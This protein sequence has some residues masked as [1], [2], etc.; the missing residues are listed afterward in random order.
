MEEGQ[1]DILLAS[2][3]FMLIADLY[4]QL[5]QTTEN[6]HKHGILNIVF[7]EFPEIVFCIF[8]LFPIILVWEQ[9]TKPQIFELL[10]GKVE[11][12]SET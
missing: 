10:S 11:L 3:L 2:A 5:F 1:Q 9:S 6:V 7:G 8:W 12:S 4:D